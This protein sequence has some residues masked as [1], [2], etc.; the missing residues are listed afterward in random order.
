MLLIWLSDLPPLKSQSN[1]IPISA[2]DIG[3]SRMEFTSSV[4][5]SPL[6]PPTIV[7]SLIELTPLPRP[8][9]GEFV[10]S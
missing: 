10:R 2:A 8:C 7:S 6:F 3:F 1:P 4:A 5:K 9:P